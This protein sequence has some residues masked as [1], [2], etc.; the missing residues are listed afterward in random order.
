MRFIDKDFE[1]PVVKRHGEELAKVQLDEVSL[2]ER[3]KTKQLDSDSLYRQVRSREVIPHFDELRTLLNA[4]QGGLCCY[5]GSKLFYPSTGHYSVEHVY[6]RSKYPEWVGEYKNLLLSCHTTDEDHA[7][8]RTTVK[9]K[10]ERKQWLHCDE[11]KRDKEIRH[12]PLNED[13]A[14]HYIYGINGEVKGSDQDAEADIET[15]NLNCKALVNRRQELLLTALF[16]GDKMLKSES[17]R[18]YR[19]KL[20]QRKDNGEYAEFYFVIVNVIDQLIAK[21]HGTQA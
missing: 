15:L 19:E 11:A 5:C 13:C 6:P 9:K 17:L 20:M 16:E 10:K 1:H 18:E 3:K 7:L 4:E 21:E 14:S 2:N 12:T 8:L